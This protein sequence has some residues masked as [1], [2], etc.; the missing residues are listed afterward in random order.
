MIIIGV[1]IVAAAAALAVSWWGSRPPAALPHA[2]CGSA[3]THGAGAGTQLLGAD[4]GALTCFGTAARGCRAASL[5]VHEMGVDTGTNYVFTIAPGGTSCQ[6]TELRQDYS[7][8]FGGSV[9]PVTTVPCRRASL[10][11]RGVLLK[12]GGQAVLIPAKVSLQPL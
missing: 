10:T 6:V 4:P 5:G 3:T 8:N 12:C 7:A 1:V 11:T 2:S 9:G